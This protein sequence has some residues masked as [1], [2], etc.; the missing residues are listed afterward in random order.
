MVWFE[1]IYN[2]IKGLDG[3]VFKVVKFVIN[4]IVQVEEKNLIV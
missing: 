2:L 3:N 1:V 4:V